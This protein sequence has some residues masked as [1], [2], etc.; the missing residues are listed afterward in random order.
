M[1]APN[2][3]RPLTELLGGLAGD[4]SGLFRKEIQLA[5]AEASEKFSQTLGGF[6]TLLAGAVLAL[7]AL[8]VFLSALVSLL[9]AFFVAQGMGEAFAGALASVIVT[10]VVGL[11]ASALIARGLN[12][13]KASNLKLERTASS[14]GHDADVVKERL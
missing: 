11:I 4:I 12:T 2:E 10:V 3:A 7:G 5:K 1:S 9:A 6:Q 14:L 8:G 13:L